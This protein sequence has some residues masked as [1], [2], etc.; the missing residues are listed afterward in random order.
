MILYSLCFTAVAP[1]IDLVRS[2]GLFSMYA[3]P[4]IGQASRR[5][6]MCGAPFLSNLAEIST[7]MQ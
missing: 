1:P 3:L 5:S 7:L 4:T 2:S 6:H